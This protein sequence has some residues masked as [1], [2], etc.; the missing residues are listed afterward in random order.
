MVL[1][2]VGMKNALGFGHQGKYSDCMKC[3]VDRNVITQEQSLNVSNELLE[4]LKSVPQDKKVQTVASAIH[5]LYEDIKNPK[6]CSSNKNCGRLLK[7][8]IKNQ[9]IPLESVV[10]C[11]NRRREYLNSFI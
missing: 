1:D 6:I 3:L 5:K 9:A 7:I 8:E 2:L 11:P 4:A 10:Y